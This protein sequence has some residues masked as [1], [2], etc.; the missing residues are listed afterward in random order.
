MADFNISNV[1]DLLLLTDARPPQYKFQDLAREFTKYIAMQL[2]KE[3]LQLE[4]GGDYIKRLFMVNTPDAVRHVGIFDEDVVSIIDLM[5]KIEIPWV[6]FTTSY[7]WDINEVNANASPAQLVELVKTRR[8]AAHKN[9]AVEMEKK[10]FTL[11]SASTS[12]YPFGFPFWVVKNATEGFNGGLPTGYTNIGG[13]DLD[14]VSAF[15]NWTATYSEVSEADLGAKLS[16]AYRKCGYEQPAGMTDPGYAKSA[17]Q[18]YR[19]YTN[20][21][22]YAAMEQIAQ[23]AINNRNA[24]FFTLEDRDGTGDRTVH[25]RGKRV[26]WVPFFDDDT[27][28][29]IYQIDNSVFYAFARRAMNM[30]ETGPTVD[31]KRHNVRVTYIDHEYQYMCLDRA[32][33]AVFYKA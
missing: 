14:V 6:R 8:Y 19:Y 4:G 28:D 9:I 25:F 17:Y 2:F 16:R 22:V 5:A 3:N 12:L 26:V 23:A 1:A 30:V 27:T 31:P 21:R 7:A 32:R 11:P 18:N 24:S 33:C 10:L 29:P 13:I 20:E 15:K